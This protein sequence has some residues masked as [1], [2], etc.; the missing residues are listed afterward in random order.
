M[1]SIKWTAPKCS[2]FEHITDTFEMEIH[3]VDWKSLP[4][5]VIFHEVWICPQCHNQIMI[6]H[7][8]TNTI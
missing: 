7:D 1:S 3:F 5:A 2:S 8:L 6:R 4:S